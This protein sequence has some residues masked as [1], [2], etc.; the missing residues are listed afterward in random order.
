MTDLQQS[1]S[2][3]GTANAPSRPQL[4]DHQFPMKEAD[5]FG[6]SGPYDTYP[7]N[8]SVEGPPLTLDKC[9]YEE[10]ERGLCLLSGV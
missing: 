8:Q 4:D 6:A 9:Y 3:R 5:L 2:T 7:G 1:R 10:A